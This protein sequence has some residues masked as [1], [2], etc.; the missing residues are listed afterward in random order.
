MPDHNDPRTLEQKI[1]DWERELAD[2]KA[3]LATTEGRAKSEADFL[4]GFERPERIEVEETISIPVWTAEDVLNVLQKY[5]DTLA[6]EW[7]VGGQMRGS[8]G[9]MCRDFMRPQTD[10]EYAK[11]VGIA[12]Q[13]YIEDARRADPDYQNRRKAVKGLNRRINTLERC[14]KQARPEPTIQE[15]FQALIPTLEAT[16]EPAQVA[17]LERL[18]LNQRRQC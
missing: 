9:M 5:P 14:L 17:L 15:Q 12:R 4:I 18:V 16:L 8:D 3:Q 10:P 11:S 2:A 13:R 7:W 6:N 1:A